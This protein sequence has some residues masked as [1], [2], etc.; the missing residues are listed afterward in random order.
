MKLIPLL[1]LISGLAQAG[2]IARIRVD[3]GIPGVSFDG[4][5]GITVSDGKLHSFSMAVNTPDNRPVNDTFD[6]LES[7]RI[8]QDRTGSARLRMLPGFSDVTGGNFRLEATRCGGGNH[9]VDFRLGQDASGAWVAT[10]GSR[11]VRTVVMRAQVNA[12]QR[13][14]EGCFNGVRVQ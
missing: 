5:L 2:Q 13:K 11:R 8:L 4:S 1:F 14:F 12:L 7:G 6:S 10:Q 9:S 3:T